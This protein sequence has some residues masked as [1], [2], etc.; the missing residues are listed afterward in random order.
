MQDDTCLAAQHKQR[1][2][3]QPSLAAL[4]PLLA[5]M[6]A[7]SNPNHRLLCPAIKDHPAEKGQP[8]HQRT[9]CT[10]V[11]LQLTAPMKRD[12]THET[13]ACPI[14]HN[15]TKSSSSCGSCTQH[16]I[17]QLTLFTLPLQCYVGCLQS[18]K[19]KYT[20]LLCLAKSQEIASC[21]HPH[22]PHSTRTDR[23]ILSQQE[24]L[25]TPFNTAIKV[26]PFP[27]PANHQLGSHSSFESR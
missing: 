11:A 27:C 18:A 16:E 3:H 22:A 4:A 17:I 6:P 8:L 12:C 10:S 2:K 15:T 7:R 13:N 26:P 20:A 14:H 9:R 5:L 1:P 24:P 19:L 21:P 25:R 23:T